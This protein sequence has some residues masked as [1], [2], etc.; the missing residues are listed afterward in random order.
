MEQTIPISERYQ[1]PGFKPGY[2]VDGFGNVWCRHSL[3]GR[4][5]LLSKWRK[6]KPFR[7][8]KGYLHISVRI[9]GRR[10]NFP[11]HELMLRTFRGPRPAR[12]ECRH[13]DGNKTNNRIGNLVW[14]TAAE[15][16]EDKRKHGT[17]P[18]GSRNGQAKLT[19][20]DVEFARAARQKEGL[21]FA[22][23][24]RAFGVDA[25]TIRRAV[26]RTKWRHVARL[27]SPDT[28][29][30]R[31]Q[32]RLS[33]E[34][35]RAV[36]GTIYS[37]H[38][39]AHAVIAELLGVRVSHCRVRGDA[40]GWRGAVWFMPYAGITIPAELAISLAGTAFERAVGLPT[41]TA[42]NAGDRKG[43]AAVL[44]WVFEGGAKA[45]DLVERSLTRLF[46]RPGIVAA[47][48]AVAQALTDKGYL[49]GH[50]VRSL[51]RHSLGTQNL[52]AAK[53]FVEQVSIDSVLALLN[54]TNP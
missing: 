2:A 8:R 21:S 15:N 5:P 31:R 30:R 53:A 23:L 29:A 41:N 18:R 26:L 42:P 44:G 7:N 19:E 25:T 22:E 46:S 50:K 40:E 37:I 9:A 12:H 17:I 16:T 32:D 11:V 49:P 43:A 28:A 45:V 20:E 4:G 33:R 36:E 10:R 6:V 38:E 47:V 54:P 35:G 1:I 39:A 14:G 13:L 34:I 3:N 51:I 24:A 27:T 48:N 52:D